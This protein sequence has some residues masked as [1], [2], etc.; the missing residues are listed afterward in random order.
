MALGGEELD[1]SDEICG[2]V[3]SLRSKVDLIQLWT[4]EKVNSIGRKFVKA[5]R[6]L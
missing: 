3:V 5:P 1:K 4:R 2:A 6:R